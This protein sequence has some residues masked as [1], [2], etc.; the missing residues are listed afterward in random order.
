MNERTV[1]AGMSENMG[2]IGRKPG[3]GARSDLSGRHTPAPSSNGLESTDKSGTFRKRPRVFGMVSDVVG[4]MIGDP[5]KVFDETTGEAIKPKASSFDWAVMLDVSDDTLSPTIA[6]DYNLGQPHNVIVNGQRYVH[7]ER[8]AEAQAPTPP[9]LPP[10]LDMLRNETVSAV[11]ARPVMTVATE[12]MVE[13]FQLIAGLRGEGLK[14]AFAAA[15]ATRKPVDAGAIDDQ[16][17]KAA[18][19]SFEEPS[20]VELRGPGR[21]SFPR[22]HRA[23]GKNFV[24]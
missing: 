5:V 2:E 17:R 9:I 1:T 19:E 11:G 20:N 3:Q 4:G 16:L 24:D 21:G 15:K 8:I 6:F 23:E 22:S 7:E 13:L 18:V 14:R 12:H 10:N